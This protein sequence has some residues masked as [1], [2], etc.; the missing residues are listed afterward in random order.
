MFILIE[1]KSKFTDLQVSDW[2]NEQV[3]QRLFQWTS[4]QW[5]SLS[6]SEIQLEGRIDLNGGFSEPKLNQIENHVNYNTTT[7]TIV[8]GWLVNFVFLRLKSGSLEDRRAWKWFSI[9]NQTK[10][11]QT[12]SIWLTRK[13]LHKF[14]IKKVYL[15]KKHC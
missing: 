8:S 14:V 4:F 1:R 9:S 10:V 13:N 6:I 12:I 15:K 5:T 2:L 11:L 7:I 3:N